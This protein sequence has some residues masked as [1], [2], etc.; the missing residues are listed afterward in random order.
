MDNLGAGIS[1]W[2]ARA[3]RLMGNAAEVFIAGLGWEHFDVCGI[4]L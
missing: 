3:P 4:C 1:W 2:T